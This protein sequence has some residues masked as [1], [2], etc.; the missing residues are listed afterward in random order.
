MEARGQPVEEGLRVAGERLLTQRRRHERT[1][2]FLPSVRSENSRS[3]CGSPADRS[4]VCRRRGRSCAGRH[5]LSARA[6]RTAGLTEPTMNKPSLRP[7]LLALLLAVSSLGACSVSTSWKTLG[8]T[9][10]WQPALAAPSPDIAVPG[11]LGI[12]YFC[13]TLEEGDF[14]ER[15]A[16]RIR[17]AA[18]QSAI[19]PMERLTDRTKKP[20]YEIVLTEA[21]RDGTFAGNKTAGVLG[22][23]G[24]GVATGLS[25]RHVGLAFGGALLAGGASYLAFA[26]KKDNLMFRVEC[27]QYTSSEGSTKLRSN[28]NVKTMLS[29]ITGQ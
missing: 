8:G 14:A 7:R 26:E 17:A 16:E 28:G 29:A 22:A 6:T 13:P 24:G 15:L 5:S 2:P 25:T 9:P 11:T 10:E 1:A 20:H 3:V 18:A 23:I 4:L 27:Y 12:R 21:G 19:G